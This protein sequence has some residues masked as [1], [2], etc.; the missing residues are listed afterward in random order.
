MNPDFPIHAETRAD[1]AHL[2]P[3][4]QV[5]RLLTTGIL[6]GPG[7]VFSDAEATMG[8][9][10]AFCWGRSRHSGML[11][12]KPGYEA[13]EMLASRVRSVTAR[14]ANPVAWHGAVLDAVMG[15]LPGQAIPT[16]EALWW[17]SASSGLASSWWRCLLP[18]TLTGALTAR[19][20][21]SDILRQL[22]TPLPNPDSE[23]S[24]R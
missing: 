5:R 24:S 21:A 17:R 22:A 18:E 19:V 8:A 3:L 15:D 4:E 7:I 14:S 9:W 1:L 11:A 10:L 6:L 16:P 2:H 13:A 12:N 23:A 20:V